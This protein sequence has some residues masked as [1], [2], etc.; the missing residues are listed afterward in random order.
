LKE[1]E[2]RREEVVELFEMQPPLN[3]ELMM[4]QNYF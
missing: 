3:C 1:V 2:D 4:V